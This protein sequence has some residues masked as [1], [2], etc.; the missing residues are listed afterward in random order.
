[1]PVSLRLSPELEERY[2]HLAEQTNRPRSFYM[3]RALEEAIERLEWEYQILHD[4]EEWN[5][6]RLKTYTLEEVAEH[7]GLDD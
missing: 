2:N 6:G 1:M 5:A 7:C 4:V 3:R